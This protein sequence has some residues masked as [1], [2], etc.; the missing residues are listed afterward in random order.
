MWQRGSNFVITVIIIIGQ[1]EFDFR[2]L[3]ESGLCWFFAVA[4]MCL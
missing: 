4:L 1:S 2:G 3:A